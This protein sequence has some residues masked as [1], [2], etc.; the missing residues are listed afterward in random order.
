MKARKED[1][2]HLLLCD[3]IF[4]FQ[5]SRQC[6][7]HLEQPVGSEMLLQAELRNIQPLKKHPRWGKR[8][9]IVVLS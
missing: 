7:T 9:S 1:L 8:L 4:Q 5:Q 2:V 3:A 6:H